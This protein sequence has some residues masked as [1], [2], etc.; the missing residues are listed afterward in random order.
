MVPRTQ[1]SGATT[2]GAKEA[3]AGAAL[4]EPKEMSKRAPRSAEGQSGK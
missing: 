2:A 4:A 3:R 1:P